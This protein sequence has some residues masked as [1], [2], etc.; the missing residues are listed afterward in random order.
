M[1]AP[2]HPVQIPE[3]SP[4]HKKLPKHTLC[5]SHVK[6]GKVTRCLA[7]PEAEAPGYLAK[8]D[9]FAAEIAAIVERHRDLEASRIKPKGI[10][11]K[12][13][14]PVIVASKPHRHKPGSP[15]LT[16]IESTEPDW[17]KCHRAHVSGSTYVPDDGSYVHVHRT[18]RGRQFLVSH[19][20]G[21]RSC[22]A[23]IERKAREAAERAE[24]EVANPS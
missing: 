18:K 9:V 2:T 10:G 14:K 1:N 13:V 7:V 3:W 17:Y 8:L 4:L 5:L 23:T 15:C 11:P 22:P 21:E 12:R 20:Q 19:L 16:P 6:V 24:R